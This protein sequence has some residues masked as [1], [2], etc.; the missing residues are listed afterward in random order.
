MTTASILL[1]SL[2]AR[3]PR[4]AFCTPN[5]F[6]GRAARRHS[7]AGLQD[8]QPGPF[9]F[10][11]PTGGAAPFAAAR[12]RDHGNQLDLSPITNP[13]ISGFLFAVIRSL[14][15]SNRLLITVY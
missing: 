12:W 8:T 10:V 6:T 11:I 15:A 14:I 9:W 3:L 4:Y 7:S 5:S 1:R 13:R 2:M